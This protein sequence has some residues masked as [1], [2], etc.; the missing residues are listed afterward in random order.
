MT[1]VGRSFVPLL[2]A[3]MVAGS[4]A[5]LAL[6]G[7]AKAATSGVAVESPGQGE[8]KGFVAT[9]QTEAGGNRAF[10]LAPNSSW[11][12]STSPGASGARLIDINSGITLRFLTS[13][14]LR[15]AALS[16]SPDSKTVFARDDDGHVVA[17]NAATGRP[18]A[19]ELQPD[20][21]EIARLSLS[22]ES[23]DPENR[24][25]P[26]LLS[27]Y[28]LQSHFPELKQS[29]EIMLNPTQEYAIVGYVGDADWKTFQ[30]WDLKKERTA[31]FFRLANDACGGAPS[32]FDY[33]G[34][35]LVFG[36]SGGGCDPNHI[37]FT[38]FEISYSRPDTEPRTAKATQSL[39]IK[40]SFPPDSGEVAS[41]DFAISP[42]GNLM[43][44][45]GGM[46]GSPEW[47]AWDLRNGKQFASI[48]P[49][50]YGIVSDD[51]STIVVLHDLQPDDP[52]PSQLM[53]VRRRGK[54]ATFEI[55]R[56]MQAQNW[57]PVILS[58]NG[59]WIASM[60]GGKVAVWSSDDG[61]ILKE[62]DV[63]DRGR[64]TDILR[65]S[66]T[67]DP[68]LINEDEGTAFVKGTWQP[69][70][71]VE[72]G[73]IVPLT[74]YFHAECGVIFCDRVVADLG[75]VERKSL[76]GPLHAD[77]RQNLSAD[78][79][80][81]IVRLDYT[82]S[83]ASRGTNITDIVDG[84]V[85]M[86]L[87]EFPIQFLSDGAH[88]IARDADFGSFVKYEIATGKRVWTAIPN[89]RRNG[90]HMILPDGHVRYTPPRA[91]DLRL[92]RGF[93]IRPFDAA[94]AKQFV[95]PSDR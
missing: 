2:M 78:G 86:H 23:N 49:D 14:G 94:A 76:Q 7:E 58:P 52:S 6:A 8:L 46:P 9:P 1:I 95:A 75:V 54:K 30:V 93:D 4:S 80:F 22:Y 35:H 3:V 37:D 33:D 67:G 25:P 71:S 12:L 84:H 34:K 90:F 27:R 69:V 45:G 56:S 81:M 28:H 82:A 59:Q 44:R 5:G 51:D 74:P 88:I 92:V 10:L 64:I 60:V 38:V 66:N 47:A 57:R 11:F 65:L 72:N 32:A 36:N 43:M 89:W 87:D 83:G 61:K 77:V 26:E 24:A 68:L 19:S 48:R 70:R 53:T 73:L 13:P 18:A 50:G 85:V 31:V 91:D 16:I 29:N 40:C 42:S 55:P 17:W 15:I 39:G 20:L 62:Y 41:Q 21:H 79:R 63:G